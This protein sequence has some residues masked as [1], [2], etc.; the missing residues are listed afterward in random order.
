MKTASVLLLVAL[1]AVG[2]NITYALSSPKKFEKPGKCP[3]YPPGCTG[4][5]FELCSG[6]QSCPNI[7]KC[8]PIACGHA[9]IFPVFE[10]TNSDVEYG[11]DLQKH[12]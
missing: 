2:M 1:I 7:Q 12:D 10:I 3:K 6:D 8:C 9:C 11:F 4:M 5:C